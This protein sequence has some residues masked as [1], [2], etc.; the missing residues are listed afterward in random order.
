MVVMGIISDTHVEKKHQ[1][2]ELLGIPGVVWNK[3]KECRQ[4]I[5]A[6]DI[7]YSKDVLPALAKIAPLTVVR[8]NHDRRIKEKIPSS[9]FFEVE[10]WRFWVVHG[11][12]GRVRKEP[13]SVI[14][15]LK[16]PADVIIFGH[17]HCPLLYTDR[18]LVLLN[19]GS[20]SNTRYTPFAS[21]LMVT[22]E[23]ASIEVTLYVLNK[24]REGI[25]SMRKTRFFKSIR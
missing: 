13:L 14:G 18:D 24:S 20:I 10:G 12:G 2:S 23:K 22:V 1:P 15:F 16:E 17:T 9:V 3:L 7:G 11:H 4:I 6:G 19:P 5:H 21:F 25:E 8:G